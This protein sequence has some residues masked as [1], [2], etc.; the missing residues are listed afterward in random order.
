[1][2]E[3]GKMD[4]AI[5]NLQ[6]A[7]ELDPDRAYIHYQLQKAYRQTGKSEAANRELKLYQEL[8]ERDRQRI[9]ID[10]ERKDRSENSS[11]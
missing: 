4:E 1:M 3:E 7:A 6:A 8:K 10:G 5:Q 9:A 2:L 11:D